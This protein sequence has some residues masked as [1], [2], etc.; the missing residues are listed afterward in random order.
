[1]PE[2]VGNSVTIK[3]PIEILEA[4]VYH[5]FDFN[6][7]HPIPDDAEDNWVSKHWTTKCP[8][9]P[10]SLE[11][12][13]FSHENNT[14]CVW[15]RTAWSSPFALFAYMTKK[16]PELEISVIYSYGYSIDYIGISEYK[17]GKVHDVRIYPHSEEPKALATFSQK[18]NWFDYNQWKNM[19][20]ELGFENLKSIDDSPDSSIE[21]SHIDI[22][23]CTYDTIV[24]EYDKHMGNWQD[25]C[26]T[27]IES[28]NPA[29][30]P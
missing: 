3:G 28:N 24:C 16:H 8:I 7:I 18:N 17:Y 11:I 5:K 25:K 9:D 6:W 27:C 2:Y 10:K 12:T 15:F 19:C 29:N 14:L 13:D 4:L 26:E 20:I 23:S 21:L 22:R 30:Y 1:M